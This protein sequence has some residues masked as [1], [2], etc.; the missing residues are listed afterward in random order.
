M[1]VKVTLLIPTYNRPKYLERTLHFLKVQKTSIPIIV[2][3]GSNTDNAARNRELCK[4][5]GDDVDYFH[6]PWQADSAGVLN[7]YC[8][9]YLKAVNQVKTAYVA[10]CADDDLPIISSTLRC[11]EFLDKQPEFVAC[12]GAY[13]GFRYV[14]RGILIDELHYSGPS[15]DGREAGGR[16]MQLHA[17]Y[18]SLYYAVFRTGTQR[19]IINEAMQLTPVNFIE[20]H[21]STLAVLTGK[22]KRLDEIYYF[23]NLSVKPHSR[24]YEGWYEWLAKDFDQFFSYYRNHRK[25]VVDYALSLPNASL[26]A[27]A[28]NH[29]LDMAFILYVG[30]GFSLPYW[31]D[32]YLAQAII[33]EEER[34]S[35]RR[36]LERCLMPDQRH[37][38]GF[39]I[40]TAV[41]NLIQLFFGEKGIKMARKLRAMVAGAPVEAASIQFLNGQSRVSVAASVKAH[42]PKAQWDALLPNL[43][44]LAEFHEQQHDSSLG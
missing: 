39:N 35:I 38:V 29:A 18:E 20:I 8:E 12:H 23:R 5:Y 13:L 22:I 6:V 36:W 16:L 4:D 31:I 40:R 19:A 27:V 33:D 7:N 11:V 2:A 37:D 3:D 34:R 43:V 41:K 28:Y 14:P 1:S 17:R 15:I 42:F 32:H 44:S 21:H 26:D 10:T 25:R 24:E 9:R 30:R